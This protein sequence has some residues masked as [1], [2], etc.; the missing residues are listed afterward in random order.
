VTVYRDRI[1]QYERIVDD[2]AR[3]SRDAAAGP[4]HVL[5]LR[6]PAGTPCVGQ[7]ERRPPVLGTAAAAAERLVEEALG[8]GVS[9]SSGSP[10]TPR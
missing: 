1:A 7:L 9:R 2:I 3:R 6:P 10:P 8:A 4:P 5:G